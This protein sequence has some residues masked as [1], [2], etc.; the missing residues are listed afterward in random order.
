LY[1]PSHNP[2]K[3]SKVIM[4]NF[5]PSTEQ[6]LVHNSSDN[7]QVLV[8]N[9]SDNEQALVSS[10]TY[11]NNKHKYIY[12][13]FE[14]VKIYFLKNKRSE[15]EAEKFFNYY[16]STGWKTEGKIDISNWKEVARNWIIKADE[17]KKNQFVSHNVITHA[18]TNLN[19]KELEAYYGNRV[20][21]RMRAM[22]NLISF[23]QNTTDKRI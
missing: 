18:T 4:F 9:R 6:V 5:C 7:E 11:I 3:G 1:Q 17:I 8:H 10:K 22:F 12:I 21:S 2:F 16:E 19:S 15:N 23:G 20:R 13:D 14:S